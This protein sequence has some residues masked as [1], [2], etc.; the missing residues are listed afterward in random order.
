MRVTI[1][2]NNMLGIFSIT[3]LVVYLFIK[4]KRYSLLKDDPDE[5]LNI[6]ESVELDSNIRTYNSCSRASILN[7]Y[8]KIL[9]LIGFIGCAWPYL[10]VEGVDRVAY[11]IGI[12]SFGIVFPI[13]I[14]FSCYMDFKCADSSI[15][16]SIDKIEYKRRKSFAINVDEIKKIT[17]LG[18]FTYQIHLKEKGKRPLHLNLDEYTK[19]KELHSLIKQIRDHSAKISGRDKKVAHKFSIWGFE[20]FFGKYYFGFINIVAIIVLFYTSYC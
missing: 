13:V 16:I 9:L 3:C 10:F 2:R 11:L 12:L 8:S 6:D 5:R 19:K 7:A 20:T 1:L 14:V 4:F 15:R 17:D 18:L